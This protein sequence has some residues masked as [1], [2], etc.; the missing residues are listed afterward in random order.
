M[1]ARRLH[2]K[3]PFMTTRKW[4]TAMNKILLVEDNTKIQHADKNMLREQ[5]YDICL[6][7][8]I[9][10]ARAAVVDFRPDII[11]LDI[12]LPDG[13]GMD[14]LTELRTSEP[15]MPVLFLTAM[16]ATEDIIA[17]LNAGGDDYMTKPYDYNVFMSRIKAILRREETA[18]ERIKQATAGKPEV[19]QCGTLTINSKTRIV[20]LDGR[21]LNL[22]TKQFGLLLL[23]IRSENKT[24]DAS[25]LYREVWGQPMG[26]DVQALRKAISRIRGEIKGSGYCISSERG[27]GYRFER[28]E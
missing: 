11:V 4:W 9:A 19:L 15:D 26:D 3:F 5:G 17:G 13:N 23:L 7:M 10:E 22:H 25:E 27:K 16:G 6:A 21:V 8:T 28:G 24:L 20:H 1:M 12:M 2:L 18:R 14:F